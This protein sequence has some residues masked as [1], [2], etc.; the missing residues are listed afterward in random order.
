MDTDLI[1]RLASPLL[2]LV[3]GAIIKYYTEERS[4]IISFLGHVSV[5]TLQGE[6]KDESNSSVFT[7]SIIV[8]NAGRRT[9]KN[10]RLGHNILPPSINVYP[11]VQYTIEHNPGGSS[12]I[13]IPSLVPKEQ[14]TV[15]Y[16]YFPPLTWDQINTYTKSDDGLAKIIDVIPML[17]P[18]KWAL[19]IVWSLVFIGASVLLYWAMKIIANL[20]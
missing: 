8:R 12:E 18:P 7:H 17:R 11:K 15:S 20:I 6:N 14:V 13:V 16:L 1:L 3:F 10:I 2:T 19:V 9:A 5:F 4:K